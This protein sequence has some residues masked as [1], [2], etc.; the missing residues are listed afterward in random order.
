MKKQLYALALVLFATGFTFGQTSNGTGGGNWITPAT[1]QGNVAPPS[2]IPNNSSISKIT[3]A[4]LDSVFLNQTLNIVKNDFALDVVGKLTLNKLEASNKMDII[5]RSTGVL[6]VI[7]DIDVENSL[8][9]TVE[10]GGL[11]DVGGKIA[12][13]NSAVLTIDGE[14]AAEIITGHSGN[15]NQ[16]NGNGVLYLPSAG[17]VTGIT[18]NGFEGVIVYGD[19]DLSLPAPYNLTATVLAGPQVQLNWFFP[20]SDPLTASFIGY[21][22]FRNNGGQAAYLASVLGTYTLHG[23]T[24]TLLD[25]DIISYVDGDVENLD[26]PLYYVRAVYFIDNQIKYSRIS[27]VV[28]FRKSALPVELLKFFAL[29]QDN[30][31]QLK[32]STASETNNMGFELQRMSNGNWISIGFVDGHYNHNGLLNYAFT[33]FAP[34]QGV[35]YYRMKQMDYDGAFKFYGPVVAYLGQQNKHFDIR[36]LKREGYLMVFLPSDTEGML[37]VFDLQG[38]MVFASNAIGSITLPL[39]KGI[40]IVRFSDGYHTAVSKILH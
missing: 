8:K 16:L 36:T 32:W 27:N 15:S 18:L 22:V 39:E 4:L 7:G 37:E 24:L 14:L 10:E 12:L 5:V 26:T 28:D 6:K 17:A 29:T 2:V 34:E 20:A 1:W 21:Q 31:V 3:I 30:Q 13:K 35:N 40:Y 23:T 25:K 33:D 9:I 19:V 11:L 38:R